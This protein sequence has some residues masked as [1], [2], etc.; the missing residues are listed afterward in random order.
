VQPCTPTTETAVFV[1]DLVSPPGM[2]ATGATVRLGYASDL[3]SIPGMGSQRSVLDRV[4]PPPPPP[5]PFVVNDADY[6]I[7][8]VVGRST[9]IEELFTLT[10]DRC[11]GAR[12][13]AVDDLGCAIVGCALGGGPIEGCSCTVR[14]P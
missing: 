14:T 6:A 4:N 9:P 13:P 12:A 10:F 8:V 7:S 1:F 2:A 3:L 5:L 11:E